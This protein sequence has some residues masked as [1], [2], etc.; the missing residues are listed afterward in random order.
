MAD[1]LV[2]V[3]VSGLDAG[4]IAAKVEP[5]RDIVDLIEIRLDAMLKPVVEE[6]M[7]LIDMDLLFT[8]R[9]LWEGGQ[10]NGSEEERLAPLLKAISGGAAFVDLE[11]RSGQAVRDNLLEAA[12]NS[13]TRCIFSWHDFDMTPAEDELDKL[14][15][16]MKTSGAD[17]AKIVTTA[18]DELAVLR[19]LS[20]QEKA[21]DLKLDLSCFCMG[22]KGRISR[23]SSL[24][25]G[26]F[27]SYVAV[28]EQSATAPGQFSAKQFHQLQ[29]AFNHEN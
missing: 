22:E 20:L 8:N 10:F 4:D 3:S 16:S 26:G 28:D 19:V 27:M 2:C 9:P 13:V 7:D 21:A 6:C 5:I 15:I 24:Y 12:A 1:G 17:I 29:S 25:L 11:L 14:L 18:H 23:F